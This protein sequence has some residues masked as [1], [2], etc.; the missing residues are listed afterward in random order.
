MT[1]QNELMAA[2]KE[3]IDHKKNDIK[4]YNNRLDQNLSEKI[5]LMDNL[6]KDVNE[7]TKVDINMLNS[8]IDLFDISD[9][10]KDNL[11]KELDIIKAVLTLNQSEKTTY[12]L[13]PDQL[14]TVAFF[15]SNLEKYIEEKNEEKQKIDPE[16]NHIISITKQYKDLLSKFKNPNNLSLVTDIDT[17]LKLFQEN[18]ITEKEKQAILLSLIKYNQEVVEK[19]TDAIKGEQTG[20]TH[21]ELALIFQRHGYN[22]EILAKEYQIELQKEGKRK[23]IEEV[24]NAMQNVEFTKID[25]KSQGILLTAFLLGTTKKSI[26]EISRVAQERGINIT[27][28]EKLVS[29]FIPKNYLYTGK[30]Q[31]GRKEDFLK[32]LSTLAEHGI[33]IPLVADKE[34]DLLIISNSTLQEN[35]EWLE[36]YGLYSDT[37]SNFLLDDFLSALKAKN[38]PE[39]IDL[40]IESHSLGLQYIRNNLSVLS[41]HLSSDTILFY[42]L[43]QSEKSNNL[44]A[45]FRLTM[46]N[47]IKKLNLR[48]EISN[49]KTPY[50]DII[51]I[52]M[53][54]RVTNAYEPSFKDK[55]KY[56][57][58]VNASAHQTISDSI[59]END[60]IKSLNK[61]TVQE[62]SL[63]YN[64][65]GLKI[66]KLKVLRIYDALCKEGLDKTLDSILFSICYRKIMTEDEY[67]K[68]VTEISQTTGM[69]E[70]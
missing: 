61:Y 36:K 66:S 59:F 68:L 46:S 11:K 64:I 4:D 69:K 16:Y 7:I 39:I 28:I 45:A 2:L 37:N 6:K 23:N 10:K 49:E 52:K 18:H 70:V 63:L 30:Y 47:G 24:F 54:K 32:N 57:E 40:W 50:Q 42:K 22:Y 27:T 29:A 26:E 51:N 13:L 43:Y 33:S 56:L 25:E 19:K 12:T 60:V 9:S 35:L 5:N 65:N 48:K 34:K 41:N 8:V 17:L 38:I 1:E 31:I 20:L 62:E 44:A 67:K 21:Q 53:A 14:E 55:A 15:I 58:I 3:A